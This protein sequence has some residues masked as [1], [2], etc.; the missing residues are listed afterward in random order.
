MDSMPAPPAAPKPWYR[1]KSVWIGAAAALVVIGA[2]SGGGE[3]EPASVAPTSTTSTTVAAGEVVTTSS[4]VPATS[5]S[6][7]RPGNP[8]VYSRIAAMTDCGELQEQFDLAEKT[9]KRP[10]GTASLG[11]WREIGIAYMEAADARMQDTGCY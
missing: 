2:A 1:K 7:A 8:D 9:S 11:T 5:P 6:K 3:K 10:G 4:S